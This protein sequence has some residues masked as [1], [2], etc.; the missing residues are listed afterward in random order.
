MCNL[1]SI[2]SLATASVT[3]V[4][5]VG[6][7]LGNATNRAT[8]YRAESG[9]LSNQQHRHN[10][11]ADSLPSLTI[12]DVSVREGNS[13]TTNANFTVSLSPPPAVAGSVNF[14]TANQTAS[15]P[16]DYSSTNGVLSFG[17]GETNKTISVSVNGNS[18][19]GGAN[20][21]FLV[22]LTGAVNATLIRTSGIGTIVN[23]DATPA[24]SIAD[25]TLLEGN[26][27]TTN[28]VFVVTVSVPSSLTTT[29]SYSTV[30]GTAGS[31]I[32]FVGKSGIIALPPLVTST[33]W[34]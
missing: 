21:T 14:A 5:S 20:K 9:S 28:A 15:A 31:G 12:N 17:V 33:I 3:I 13:G 4:A 8:V 7:Q 16:G 22:L 32:D 27:G 25:A 30:G 29:F 2:D 11:D 19:Y 18:I 1:G 10:R 26:V 34:L 6:Q 24:L 23:D